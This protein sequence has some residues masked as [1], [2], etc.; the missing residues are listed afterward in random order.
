MSYKVTIIWQPTTPE[1]EIS[2]LAESIGG[3]LELEPSYVQSDTF[4]DTPYYSEAPDGELGTAPV[5]DSKDTMHK[6]VLLAFRTAIETGEHS[7][8]LNGITTKDALYFEELAGIMRGQ[9]F[10][11]TVEYVPDG[12]DH[13]TE[14]DSIS[15]DVKDVIVILLVCIPSIHNVISLVSTKS[16]GS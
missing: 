5:D 13:P 6:G 3:V 7:I 14:T 11:I 8:E 4:K 16:V 10:T 1:Y 2:K 12:G 15:F 9:G